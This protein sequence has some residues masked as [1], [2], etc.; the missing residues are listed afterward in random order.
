MYTHLLGQEALKVYHT[1]KR[2]TQKSYRDYMG[3][4]LTEE[5]TNL[6]I[7]PAAG[8]GASKKLPTTRVLFEKKIA[9]KIPS[10][11]SDQHLQQFG[12]FDP[13]LGRSCN[14]RNLAT[15]YSASYNEEKNVISNMYLG[16]CA[17][18]SKAKSLKSM[19]L[20]PKKFQKTL[21][22]A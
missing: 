6:G 12:P 3:G 16:G 20:L 13:N 5:S 21:I 7:R 14:I 9:P 18:T 10:T 11:F 2:T 17:I 15:Q 22:L 19:S 8:R 4:R 1:T